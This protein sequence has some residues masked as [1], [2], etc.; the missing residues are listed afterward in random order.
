ML[1][2]WGELAS[3]KRLF[4]PPPQLSSHVMCI[5]VCVLYGYFGICGYMLVV[6]L[7]YLFLYLS[8]YGWYAM[9]Y[10]FMPKVRPFGNYSIHVFSPQMRMRNRLKHVVVQM[11]CCCLLFGS[12]RLSD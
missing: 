7:I 2:V 8:T 10:N 4:N 3:H 6:V 11:V 9:N 12:C 5:C 1:G